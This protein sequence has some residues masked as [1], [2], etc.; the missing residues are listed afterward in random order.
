[1]ARPTTPLLL[2]SA[3]SALVA[4]AVASFGASSSAWALDAA[5]P[6]QVQSLTLEAAGRYDEAARLLANR[7][8]DEPL[9]AAL[10][11]RLGWLWFLAK[12]WLRA[13]DA[14][15]LADRLEPGAEPRIGRAWTA[16]RRAESCEARVLFDEVLAID[17][18]SASAK[19]GL[20]QAAAK[21]SSVSA[22]AVLSGQ[23]YAGNPWKSAAGAATIRAS[24][25]RERWSASATV[26]YAR[27]LPGTGA[28][29]AT[30][31]SFDQSEV[32][33]SG[34]YA[35][36]EGGVALHYGF[37]HDGSGVMGNVQVAG[38]SARLGAASAEASASVYPDQ[39]VL[40]LEP[41]WRFDLAAGVGLHASV[42]G[43]WLSDGLLGSAGVTLSVA[44]P[45]AAYWVQGRVGSEQRP[46][47]LDV[48]VA[49]DIAET[50]LAGV[51]LGAKV[52]LGD[53]LALAPSFE[54]RRL[55]LTEDSHRV[56]SDAFFFSLGLGW[57]GLGTR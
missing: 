17:Q 21:C 27:F 49:W 18:T 7:V 57:T 39:V 13:R 38:G 1:M 25:T 41:Q 32:W 55:R 2:P 40:R 37:L 36:D 34:A 50:L 12:D 10:H 16:L 45:E 31:V 29:F 8:A 52:P 44:R 3:A 35:T 22:A 14:Y 20:A 11:L 53:E 47:Y 9:D 23:R 26:R 24:A 4:A 54:W 5:D 30:P 28:G 15:D 43:Q 42:A 48:P 6:L 56:D 33:A 46:A 51:A 19:E